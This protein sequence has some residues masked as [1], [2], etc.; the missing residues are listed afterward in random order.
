MS[1]IKRV[2]NEKD[3]IE[4]PKLK[5]EYKNKNDKSI[6]TITLDDIVKLVENHEL[7]KDSIIKK[8]DLNFVKKE[9]KLNEKK[10]KMI[11]MI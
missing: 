7:K 9:N 11:I 8:E 1:D 10:L 6:Y 3:N 5:D 2:K 4:L